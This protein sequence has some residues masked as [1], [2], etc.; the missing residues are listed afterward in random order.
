LEPIQSAIA[1]IAAGAAPASGAGQ[2]GGPTISNSDT[3]GA[4]VAIGGA[5]AVSA[6]SLLPFGEM[7][8]ASPSETALSSVN[9]IAGIGIGGGSFNAS[10]FGAAP[11]GIDDDPR[12]R[13]R[14]EGHLAFSDSG[15][16]GMAAY[17]AAVPAYSGT[18]VVPEPSS[19]MLSILGVV[20]AVLFS[21][22]RSA[23]MSPGG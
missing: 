14:G 21:A 10:S 23:S 11:I 18:S 5:Q 3:A 15:F 9:S 8:G 16:A 1:S 19:L 13:F 6:P 22:R 20:A 4:V 7:N 2:I 12:H 17:G